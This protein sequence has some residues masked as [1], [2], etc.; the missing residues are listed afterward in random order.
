MTAIET[1]PCRWWGVHHHDDQPPDYEGPRLYLR[2]YQDKIG[3]AK[4][5]AHYKRHRAAGGN[6]HQRR[7]ARRALAG[8]VR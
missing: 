3:W 4:N 1:A 5:Y 8:T 6:A 2:A 7:K